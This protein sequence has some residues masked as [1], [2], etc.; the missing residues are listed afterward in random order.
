M[1]LPDTSVVFTRII[2]AEE[3][4]L[5]MRVELEFKRPVFSVDDYGNFREFYKKLFGLLNEQIII[6]KNR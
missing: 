6:K 5:S 2:S 4:H 3:D 1:M